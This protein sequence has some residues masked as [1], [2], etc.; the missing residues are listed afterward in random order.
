M[1]HAVSN[2]EGASENI[3]ILDITEASENL[4]GLLDD[5]ALKSRLAV[6]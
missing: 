5:M 3:S 4:P 1:N 2:P 6:T